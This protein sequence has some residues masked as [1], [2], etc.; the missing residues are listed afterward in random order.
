MLNGL[1]SFK[2][3]Y[4][5]IKLSFHLG[6]KMRKMLKL[7][8]KWSFEFLCF[9]ED[10]SERDEFLKFCKRVEYTIR[11]WYILQFE[12]MMVF[13]EILQHS[14]P[15]GSV[16]CFAC[17]FLSIY[18][19]KIKRN[20][21]WLQ[22][23]YSLFDPVHGAE[24][25]EQQTLSPEEV[26]TLELNFLAYLFQ[27]LL[28]VVTVSHCYHLLRWEFFLFPFL[29]LQTLM[30]CWVVPIQL[31]IISFL[32]GYAF[33]IISNGMIIQGIISNVISYILIYGL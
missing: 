4:P 12:D 26:D 30:L 28:L 13:S 29:G 11:A 32:L 2:Y 3:L 27:V 14:Y 5:K 25:L 17:L 10:R 19:F 22:Q 15:I 9:A 16:V 24:K 1:C 31:Y 20:V 6:K 23:L 8:F 33:H 7:S 21:Y 18:P